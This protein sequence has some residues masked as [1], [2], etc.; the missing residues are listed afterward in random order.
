LAFRPADLD[1]AEML[2]KKAG[3]IVR[4]VLSSN[5]PKPGELM[6]SG[7]W[8]PETRERIP[9]DKMF[10]MPQGKA[11]VWLPH[12][13]KPRVSTV[14]GYFEIP[15]LNARASANPYF[16]GGKK[17]PGRKVTRRIVAMFAAAG[18]VAGGVWLAG[19]ISGQSAGAG[20]GGSGPVA[21]AP[22]NS[23]PPPRGPSH[24]RRHHATR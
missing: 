17:Q 6:P 11:L 19:N 5:E 10:G 14:K 20:V 9:L 21:S 12:S 16:T 7:G 22:Q 8:R 18:V 2:V 3:K 24:R 1:T 15:K 23:D 13:D 4:P